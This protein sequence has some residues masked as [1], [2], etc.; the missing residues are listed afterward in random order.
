MSEPFTLLLLKLVLPTRENIYAT[1][2]TK[3]DSVERYVQALK[4]IYAR[5]MHAVKRW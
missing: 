5:F 4:M 2:F 1:I 3:N